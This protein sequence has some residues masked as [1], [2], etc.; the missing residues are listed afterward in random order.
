MLYNPAKPVDDVF[1]LGAGFSKNAGLPLQSEFTE[2]LVFSGTEKDPT[3]CLVPFLRAF[4]ARTF[5]HLDEARPEYWPN[6]E[7]IFTCLDLSANSGHHLGFGF[8]PSDLE[9]FGEL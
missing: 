4:I 6:L 7:D 2:R 5:G 3:K 9:K 1:I 8:P